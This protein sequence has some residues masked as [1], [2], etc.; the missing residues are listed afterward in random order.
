MIRIH[1]AQIL[2]RPAY[3]DP[4][5]D[6]LEE[7]SPT[8]DSNICLGKFRSEDS[9]Q[10]FL[11]DSKSEYLEHIRKKIHEIISWCINRNSNFIVFPEYSIPYQV[12]SEI[13]QLATE[14]KIVIVAG[15]HRIKSGDEIENVYNQLGTE[16]QSSL[17]TG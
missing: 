12:L 2:Y 16:I 7:P 15:T 3:F 11:I 10:S 14:N 17:L 5:V 4:P 13:K 1:L 9:I 6:F 8:L